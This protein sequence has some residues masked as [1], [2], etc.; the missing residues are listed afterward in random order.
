MKNTLLRSHSLNT[1]LAILILRSLFGILFTYYGYTK[2]QQ[3]DAIAPNF[4]DLIGIGGK[5]SF[6]LVI[7]AEFGGG[8]LIALGLFTRLATIPIFI[9]MIVAYFIAHAN[10]PFTAKQIAFVY[11]ILCPVIFLLGSGKYSLDRIIFK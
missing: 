5:L 4:P 3:Y 1:D 2:I 10:D 6:I 9:T 7:I 11:L 8:I